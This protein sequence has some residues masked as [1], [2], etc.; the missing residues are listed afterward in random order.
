MQSSMD[1]YGIEKPSTQ[2]PVTQQPVQ[3]TQWQNTQ[4]PTQQPI[5]Q[6]NAN[7]MQWST[8]DRGDEIQKN[9]ND[10]ININKPTSVDDIKKWS[11]YDKKTP[12]EKLYVDKAINYSYTDDVKSKFIAEN[13]QKTA[14]DSL[15][16][17][18][19]GFTWQQLYDFSVHSQGNPYVVKYLSDLSSI[20][21]G[22]Y[23]EYLT[24][25]KNT[26][27]M[28]A[29][30][31]YSATV[32]GVLIN[33]SKYDKTR[34]IVSQSTASQKLQDLDNKF[35]WM[36][37]E[38]SDMVTQD[39]P[40]D[41]TEKIKERLN[42]DE[43][44]T[45]TQSML[46]AQKRYKDAVAEEATLEDDVKAELKWTWATSS[47]INALVA[48][49]G[50][51]IYKRKLE[52]SN[53]IDAANWTLNSLLKND[54]MMLDAQEKTQAGK[55]QQFQ[56][57]MS[58]AKMQ[59]DMSSTQRELLMQAAQKDD[60]Q[61]RVIKQNIANAS[62]IVAS[63]NNE[64][65]QPLKESS[66]QEFTSLAQQLALTWASQEAIAQQVKSAISAKRALYGD[67][68]MTKSEYS[69]LVDKQIKMNAAQQEYNLNMEKFNWQKE[70]DEAKY[71]L[72]KYKYQMENAKDARDYDLNYNKYLL[73]LNKSK[74][75]NPLVAWAY[76]DKPLTYTY[77]ATNFDPTQDLSN[78]IKESWVLALNWAKITWLWGRTSYD[79]GLDIWGMAE[80]SPFKWNS[81]L[82]VINTWY[83]ADPDNGYGNY[84]KARD[85]RTWAIYQFSHFK[86]AINAQA[87][88]TI[89]AWSAIGL[90]WNTWGKAV[91]WPHVDVQK[92]NSQ[93][94][95][96]W[97]DKSAAS[98]YA[99]YL[100]DPSK[101]TV[102]DAAAYGLTLPQLQSQAKAYSMSEDSGT[103]QKARD[104]VELIKTLKDTWLKARYTANVSWGYIPGHTADVYNAYNALKSKLGLDTLINM[105]AQW[106]T[107]WALS[108]QELWFLSK[109][110]LS[111]LALTSSQEKWDKTL[112]NIVD[113]VLKATPQDFATQARKDLWYT[114]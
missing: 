79:H 50:K 104:I 13:A 10:Y 71:N 114:K 59:Y 80:W 93:W 106:A 32:W 63:V 21:P 61:Q 5:Q 55:Q 96:V 60:E 16:S 22:K 108:D 28:N 51:D 1:K 98:L 87:G 105:K 29:A 67:K 109:Y 69:D 62:G 39:K 65:A 97:Y 27:A 111:D 94:V 78:E 92:V 25:K 15:S 56:N 46:D 37:Q 49:R 68:A 110:A 72:D 47:Y 19:H 85:P 36:F 82:E 43:Y 112:N 101:V 77:S 17:K 58:F 83:D 88:D 18:L 74:A 45:A 4:Q 90:V 3:Q 113:K 52:A 102:K 103:M 84:V 91:T 66:F 23:N 99:Q 73:E 107:F 30:N 14:Y 20:D 33:G 95:Q 76:G 35:M 11:E 53:A 64:L 86:N 75:E 7:K 42:S 89:P 34:S 38:L 48:Q 54:Q 40:I 12:E 8:V 2:V 26:E 57:M 44:K 81:D 100:A 9:I 31:W 6:Q 24:A 41:Y 70:S